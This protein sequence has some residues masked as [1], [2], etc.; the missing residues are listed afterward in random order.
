VYRGNA[1]PG[2][3]GAYLFGDYCNGQIQALRLEGGKLAEH[4]SLGIQL[5]GLA[6]FGE[7]RD[8]TLYAFS[9]AP[10]ASGLYR[11]EPAS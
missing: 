4:R 10:G 2:L 5:D 1:I 9:I 11:I 6:S 8:G 7:G 3:P